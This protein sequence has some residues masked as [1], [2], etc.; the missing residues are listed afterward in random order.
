MTMQCLSNFTEPGIFILKFEGETKKFYLEEHLGGGR[1]NTKNFKLISVKIQRYPLPV[2]SLLIESNFIYFRQCATVS[3]DCLTNP[4][5]SMI[6]L[7]IFN[8]ESLKTINIY[9]VYD[10]P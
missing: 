6:F 1:K 9:T 3:G 5:A 4:V 2:I 7:E 10:A 8:K